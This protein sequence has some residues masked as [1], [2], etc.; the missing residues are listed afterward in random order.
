MGNHSVGRSFAATFEALEP[1]LDQLTKEDILK[2]LDKVGEKFRGADAEFDDYTDTSHPLG[3][4]LIKAFAP[5]DFPRE[6]NQNASQEE[7]DE[8]NDA[9]YEQV[10]EAFQKR[11]EF[12]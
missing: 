11:Y 6:P 12:C 5:E 8:W 3:K 4:A 7:W 9:W 10:Y 2:A 1:M